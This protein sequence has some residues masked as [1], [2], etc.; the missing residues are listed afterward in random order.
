MK[1]DRMQ[2]EWHQAITFKAFLNRKEIT[3]YVDQYYKKKASILRSIT[4]IQP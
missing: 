2:M 3:H 1:N 4:D